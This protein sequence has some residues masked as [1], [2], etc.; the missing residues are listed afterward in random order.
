MLYIEIAKYWE[1]AK[2]RHGNTLSLFETSNPRMESLHKHALQLSHL[3]CLPLNW[4]PFAAQG[5]A[6]A[7]SH[8]SALELNA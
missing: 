5:C 8:Q 6:V 4:P 3:M 2:Y 1:I 7:A